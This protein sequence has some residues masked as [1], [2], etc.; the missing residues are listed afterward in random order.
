MLGSLREKL[1]ERPLARFLLGRGFGM[2]DPP[3]VLADCQSSPSTG[4]VD[5]GEYDNRARDY[6]DTVLGVHH[7]SEYLRDW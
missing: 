6:P 4:G 3:G 2:H 7:P 1:E 5:A